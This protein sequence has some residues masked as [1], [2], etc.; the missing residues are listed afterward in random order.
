PGYKKIYRLYSKETGKMVADLIA[1][2]DETFDFT[3]P[4]TLF[5]PEHTW[6]SKTFEDY[7]VEEL[8]KPIYINGKRV[9][10]NPSI[11][12]IKSYCKEQVSKLWDE[13]LRWENPQN[14][15]VDL[16]QKLWDL[17]HNMLK[18]KSK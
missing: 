16:S 18:N 11:E 7:R 3:K 15:Y 10:E 17:K 12:E 14:Y 8:L 13:V 5:D 9:Y 4:I 1:L 2:H 6:K